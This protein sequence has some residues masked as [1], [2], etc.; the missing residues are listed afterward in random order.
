MLPTVTID[1]EGA[2]TFTLMREGKEV[3]HTFKSFSIT[4]NEKYETVINGVS[5]V[6]VHVIDE[7]SMKPEERKKING[8]AFEG[9]LY[10]I[11]A[12]PCQGEDILIWLSKEEFDI[13]EPMMDDIAE[14]KFQR[15]EY[16]FTR[17]TLKN[18]TDY[19]VSCPLC[20]AG[21]AGSVY[22]PRCESCDWDS[23]D[24]YRQ[25]PLDHE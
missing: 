20:N 17:T 22:R 8:P 1:T 4:V 11:R 19:M 5:S 13:L 21:L 9:Q 3:I 24:A 25:H 6:W 12:Q 2:Y 23:A 7:D 15:H 10:Y 14:E 16:E 18:P